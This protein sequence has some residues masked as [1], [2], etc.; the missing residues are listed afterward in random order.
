MLRTWGSG[1][2]N[3]AGGAIHAGSVDVSLGTLNFTD[4]IL[5]VDGGSF[6][7]AGPDLIIDSVVPGANPTLVLT[8]GATANFAGDAHVGNFGTG[9]L[10]VEIGA[11]LSNTFGRIGNNLNSTGSEFNRHG[12]GA[13]GRLAVEQLERFDRGRCRQRHAERRSGRRRY[14]R[15]RHYR[16]T[17]RLTGRRLYRRRLELHRHGH[18][19]RDGLGVEHLFLFARG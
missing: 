13:R 8:N 15:R 19:D 11:Q 5:T 4:G 9:T 3:L 18:R 1:T 7:N 17:I 12:H 16:P 10:S 6:V 14:E 2:L